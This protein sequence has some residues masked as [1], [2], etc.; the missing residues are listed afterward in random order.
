VV[1]KM[2]LVNV[3]PDKKKSRRIKKYEEKDL[4][5]DNPDIC[6]HN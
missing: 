6:N 3:V 2:S 4:D 5:P 1:K